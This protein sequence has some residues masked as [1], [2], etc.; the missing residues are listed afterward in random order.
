MI[1]Y[2]TQYL[3]NCVDCSVCSRRL[4]LV[5]LLRTI[6]AQKP[7]Q[8]IGINIVGPLPISNRRKNIAKEL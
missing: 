6:S 4:N 8:I 1:R 7:F 3:L 2:I 5:P